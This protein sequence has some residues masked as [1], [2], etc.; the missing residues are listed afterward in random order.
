VIASDDVHF[1]LRH[2]ID[3]QRLVTIEIALHGA[4]GLDLDLTVVQGTQR[5]ADAAFHLC[6]DDVRIHGHAAVDAADHSVDFY[7]AIRHRFSATSLSTRPTPSLPTTL[8]SG[9]RIG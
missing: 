7:L 3:A 9:G 6:P 8:G 2:F 4:A 5:K 1:H